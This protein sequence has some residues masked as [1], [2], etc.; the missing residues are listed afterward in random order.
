MRGHDAAPFER[1]AHRPEGEA[2]VAGADVEDDR[3]PGE[4]PPVRG[5]E[6]GQVGQEL[7]GQ[8]VDDGV[9]EVLEQL[10]RGG[11]AAAGQAGQDH[12]RLFRG[13][14]ADGV[15]RG[16]GHRP[17]RLMKKIVPSN[18]RYIVPPSTNGL[19]RSPPGRRD[20]R[21]DGDAEDHV[22]PRLAQAVGRDDPD[23]RQP[24]EQDRELHD[25]AERQEHRGHE[26]EERPG[27]DVLDQA[28]RR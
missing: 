14:V 21:E 18:S 5:H 11:L 3:D 7:A 22:A 16:F 8:V 10:R 4:A 17:V 12:D 15:L 13:T 28:C 1:T 20:G 27:R 24:D 6:L 25:E 2:R 26:V 19:T 9:A 23:P